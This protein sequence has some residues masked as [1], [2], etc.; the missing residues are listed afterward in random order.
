MFIC[1]HAV[2]EKR[3]L[4]TVCLGKLVAVAKI[5]ANHLVKEGVNLAAKLVVKQVVKVV[6]KQVVKVVVSQNQRRI[7]DQIILAP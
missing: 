2:E 7:E 5:A 3:G 1:Q 4:V 6:A